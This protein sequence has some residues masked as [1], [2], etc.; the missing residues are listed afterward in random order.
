MLPGLRASLEASLYLPPRYRTRS[1]LAKQAST[2]SA[3][4]RES[5]KALGYL[6]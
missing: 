4:L 1:A 3:E 5:L 6:P 2:V